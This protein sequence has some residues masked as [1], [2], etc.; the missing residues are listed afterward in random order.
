VWYVNVVAPPSAITIAISPTAA[1][2]ALN[3]EQP[4]TATV[5]N[6]ADTS[7]IW[8]VNGIIGG[9]ATVGMVTSFGLYQPPV[10]APVAPV[11]VSA[12]ATA[13]Q[14]KS[15]SAEVTVSGWESIPGFGNGIRSVPPVIIP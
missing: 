12:T 6:S 11:V 10:T 8:K 4:F 2:V 15:A 1:V 7:V 5:A 3:G 14:T 9:D 13:D